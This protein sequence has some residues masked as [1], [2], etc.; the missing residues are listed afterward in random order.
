[1]PKNGDATLLIGIIV[2][3]GFGMSRSE[4]KKRILWFA[5]AAVLCGMLAL[6]GQRSSIFGVIV[7]LTI[8]IFT[9]AKTLGGGALRVVLISIPLI[10]IL[11]IAK[12]P[13]EDSVYELDESDRVTAVLSHTAKGTVNPTGEGSLY[14]RFETWGKLM[15]EIAYKPFGVGLGSATLAAQPREY[16][17]N[18]AIDNYFF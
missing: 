9:S 4:G 17:K 18:P 16:R 8:L 3:A 13:D 7:G 5:A 10:L 6:T 2:A 1:M 11:F 12:P 15:G 14:V